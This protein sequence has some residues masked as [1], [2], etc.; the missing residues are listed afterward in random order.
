MPPPPLRIGVLECDTPLPGT[1]SKY[2]GYGGVFTSLLNAGA[3]SLQDP[4]YPSFGPSSLQIR[5]Y[6][7]VNAQTY[8][9][10]AD[11]DGVLISGSKH[12]SFLDEPWILKLVA[13][14][15]E[16]LAQSRVRLIGVCFG[17]QIVGRAMGAKVG[18]SDRGWEVS[19]TAMDL[20]KRGQE[21]FD[22]TTLV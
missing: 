5:S 8:P 22:R 13:F 10:L 17:H 2:G 4:S 19:V 15:K 6:D 14:S 9:S 20:T 18:R 1:V 21:I 3:S 7:V 12:D 16:V 11:V